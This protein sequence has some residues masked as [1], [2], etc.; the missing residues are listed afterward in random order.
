MGKG[1]RQVA[2][3]VSL[4]KEVAGNLSTSFTSVKKDAGSIQFAAEEQP[5]TLVA[6]ATQ[7]EVS[8]GI[9]PNPTPSGRDP[10]VVVRAF[11]FGSV[12]LDVPATAFSQRVVAE[13][14]HQADADLE[15]VAKALE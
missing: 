14:Q 4:T 13:Q 1:L 7:T 6:G 11:E 8:V 12:A 5:P 3:D 2:E 15:E 9:V 10:E